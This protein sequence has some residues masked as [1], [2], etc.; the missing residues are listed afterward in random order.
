MALSV[1]PVHLVFFSLLKEETLELTLAGKYKKCFWLTSSQLFLEAFPSC[2]VNIK[3]IEVFL[4][5]LGFCFSILL[6]VTCQR[7]LESN[8]QKKSSLD[9][10]FV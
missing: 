6:Y 3:R 8:K 5:T 9:L 10:L 7:K 4:L 2:Q 1:H